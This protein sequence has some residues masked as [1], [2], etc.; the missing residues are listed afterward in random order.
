MNQTQLQLI[1]AWASSGRQQAAIELLDQLEADGQDRELIR[2]SR[3]LKAKLHIQTGNYSAARGIWRELLAEDAAASPGTDPVLRQEA[4]DGLELLERL[5]KSFRLR[6]R[7]AIARGISLHGKAVA[8]AILF[9]AAVLVW[10]AVRHGETAA[11]EAAMVRTADRIAGLNR[12]LAAE[13]DGRI[14]RLSEQYR[15]ELAALDAER[16]KD[17]EVRLLAIHEAWRNERNS[18]EQQRTS[19]LKTILDAWRQERN[20][21]ERTRASELDA[22]LKSRDREHFAQAEKQNAAFLNALQAV[23]ASNRQLDAID[24]RLA[25]AE[26]DLKKIRENK[27]ERGELAVLLEKYHQPLNARLDALQLELTRL[28]AGQDFFSGGRWSDFMS[29]ELR[30]NDRSQKFKSEPVIT[31]GTG[32]DR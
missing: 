1:E 29:G 3:H 30:K 12:Q 15:Q 23:S 32:N 10:T 20:A 16:K 6:L 4:R 11:A 26:A 7:M 19:E 25:A 21:L 24:R 14:T 27:I 31:K 9:A 22:L 17:Q 28:S 2:H 5:D 8:A 18:A 13:T